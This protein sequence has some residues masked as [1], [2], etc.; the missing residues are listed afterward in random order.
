VKLSAIQRRALDWTVFNEDQSGKGKV[1][2]HPNDHGGPTKWGLTDRL[3]RKYKLNLLTVT[4]E[5]V[6]E[7]FVKEF[8]R[9][10][11]LNHDN[12]VMLLFDW[13]VMSGPKAA[14]V[15]LQLA[16]QSIGVELEVDG[17]MGP[18]TRYAANSSNP[19]VL[20]A[21][22]RIEREKWLRSLTKKDP[23]QQVFLNGWL[24]R[25]HRVITA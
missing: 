23:T 3:A 7:V 21:A 2:N 18:I 19:D 6:E 1:T 9:W 15:T 24:S 16:L 11:H 8:W 14:V 12:V 13:A 20:E 10:D 22:M 17:V 25:T 4:K 5:Q